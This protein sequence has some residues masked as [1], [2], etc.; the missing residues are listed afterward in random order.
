M[1]A[2]YEAIDTETA[3]GTFGLTLVTFPLMGVG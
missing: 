2:R 3:D 1:R